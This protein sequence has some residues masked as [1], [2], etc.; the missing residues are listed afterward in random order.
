MP[1]GN[2]FDS[3]RSL[4]LENTAWL[5]DDGGS[6]YRWRG[7]ALQEPHHSSGGGSTFDN[8]IKKVLGLSE[9]GVGKSFVYN[10]RNALLRTLRI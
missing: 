10:S 5:E 7:T 3:P 6:V 4:S 9:K 1:T 2:I 8:A